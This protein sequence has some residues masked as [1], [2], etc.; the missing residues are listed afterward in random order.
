M[1]HGG[2]KVARQRR[3]AG[4]VVQ[5]RDLADRVVAVLGQP[6]AP[7]PVGGAA[8]LQQL[9]AGATGLQVEPAGGV[10]GALGGLDAGVEFPCQAGFIA[11]V[12]GDA[13]AQPVGVSLA[14]RVP[15]SDEGLQCADVQRVGRIQLAI[16]GQA[17]GL[18]E[19][20]PGAVRCLAQQLQRAR[21][22]ALAQGPGQR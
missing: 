18:G 20:A 8:V 11:A 9:D 2:R 14:D 6:A 4:L 12:Q 10:A 5:Q 3:L 13:I 15:G 22:V 21:R 16:E 1:A 19:P 7:A 17:L